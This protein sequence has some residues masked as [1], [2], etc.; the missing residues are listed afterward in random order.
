MKWTAGK[1]RAL[2]G[3]RKISMVTAYDALTAALVDAAGIPCVLVGD[4]LANTALGY[5]DTLPVT[6]DQ[7]LHHT[8]A[9]VRGTRE[10]QVIADM[11]FMSYQVSV[12]QA[13]ENAGRFLKEAGADA[14]KI[15]GGLKRA[16]TI[17]ALVQNGI[18]VLGHV[19]LLPQSVKAAGLK[20]QGRDPESV[21]RLMDDAMA[22]EQA[23][24]YAIV[25]ECVMPDVAAKISASLSIPTIGIGSGAGCDGQ[26]LVFNDLVGLTENP[27]KFVK[28]FAA[29][30]AEI[31]SALSEFRTEVESGAYPSG[32]YNYS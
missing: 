4:S 1:I 15:E 10:A 31:R 27:P 12:E 28:Q 5:Q 21:R 26:V 22:V 23:G 13:L 14:V 3:D 18:P 24:A 30:G 17:E 25:L 19:G 7:M 16:E 6:M 9:V 11:P 2:K 29:V 32:E 8:A 20:V